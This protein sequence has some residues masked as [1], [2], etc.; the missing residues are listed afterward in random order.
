MGEDTTLLAI[1]H[2]DR[3]PH[4]QMMRKSQHDRRGLLS[5]MDC[6]R[7]KVVSRGRQE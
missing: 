3:R 6:G 1:Y 7:L 4:S 5:E 2:P